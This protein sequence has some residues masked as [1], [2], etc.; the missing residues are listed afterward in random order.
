MITLAIAQMVY[1]ICLAPFTGGGRAAQGR[2]ARQ[3]ISGSFQLQS[4][5][6]MYYLWWRCF[7]AAFCSSRIVHSPLARCENDPRRR[8][9]SLGYRVGPLQMLAFVLSSALWV[10][11]GH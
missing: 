6:S 10:W 5:T 11:R 7:V 3:S 2:A 9:I 4:D 8:A 1:F